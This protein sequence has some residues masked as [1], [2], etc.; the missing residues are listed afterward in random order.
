MSRRK[1]ISVAMSPYL[2]SQD[3]LRHSPSP[4]RRQAP[5]ASG[6]A[7]RIPCPGASRRI[8]AERSGGK[9]ADIPVR[10]EVAGIVARVAAVVGRRVAEGDEMII[11]EAM[12]MEL[13]V[14]APAAGIVAAIFVAEG[15]AV[16]EG[17]ATPSAAGSDSRKSWRHEAVPPLAYMTVAVT[18]QP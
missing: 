14:L 11:V 9:M 4:R 18:G 3:A 2:G 7:R 17:Q 15:E 12:K 16:S 8:A 10:S 5:L 6:R 1:G 13:P